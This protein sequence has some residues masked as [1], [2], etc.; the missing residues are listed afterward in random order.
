M[1]RLLTFYKSGRFWQMLIALFF[2]LILFFTAWSSNN[3]QNRN[4]ANAGTAETFTQTLESVPIDIKYDSDQYF[5]SG[6]SYDAE[7]YLT[8]TTQLAI[9]TESSGDTRHFKLVADLTNL[10]QGTSRVP[11]Q[12]KDLPAGMS[13]QVSPSTLT[14]TIG[15]KATKTFDVV[16]NIAPDRLAN[17]YEVRRVTLD[18]D[19]V[20]VTS[21]EDIISQID[22]VQ[23]VLPGDTEL[24]DDYKGDLILQAVSESGTVLASAISPAKVGAQITLNHLTKSV[25]V[26]VE[27][28]GD[29]DSSISSIS[30]DY[31][32]DH[33]T[34]SGSQEAMD[35][36]DS[37][38][39]PVDISNVTKNT[40]RTIDLTAEGVTVQPGT[41][42]VNLKVTQK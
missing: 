23:A 16:A 11:I 1:K 24:S 22:H 33:V 10:G 17:G 19:K 41:V 27:L 29:K 4:N 2:A 20:E 21:S 8:A 13:A 26:R 3:L 28:T 42:R 36:I 12:V 35:K 39:V 7:V 6:Y 9:T 25:P 38:T 32:R 30:Y 31:N 37:I 15:K 5:V 40:S 34:I 14:A 18:E